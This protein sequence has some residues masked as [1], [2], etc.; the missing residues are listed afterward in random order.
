M[1]QQAAGLT[2]TTDLDAKVRNTLEV[3]RRAV[4]EHG[5]IV[6][7]SSLGLESMVLMDLIWQHVPGVEIVTIDTGRLH[8][9]TYDLLA[10]VERLYGKRVRVIFP[11][12]EAV[13]GYVAQHGINGFYNGLAERQACCNVRKVVPF[14]KALA[15]YGA[16]ITGV[17]REQSASRA[18]AAETEFDAENGLYKVSPILDWTHQEIGEY[19]RARKLPYNSLVDKGFPS[20]GCSPCTR[21]VETGADSRSGRW[22]W[23]NADSRECGL[24]PRI[25]I[26]ASQN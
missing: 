15:G 9:E 16:W 13:Q 2:G 21:A 12:Q 7:A 11:E 20:I 24:H 25:R 6:Y 26:V 14:K 3:L 23:E 8:E 4:R 17:R 10:R 19:I 1:A 22:W 5:K 18:Q